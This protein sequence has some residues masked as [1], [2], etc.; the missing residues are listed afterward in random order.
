M[1][2]E[3]LNTHK[4]HQGRTFS[5]RQDQVRLPDGSTTCLDIV[6]H[7]G[8]VTIVPVDDQGQMWFVRQHRYAAGR[9]L[10]ELPAGSLEV[11]ELPEECA[12][13][14]IREEIG[15]SAGT[16][17]EIGTFF[18]APGYSTEFMHVFLAGDL[19]TD[20]LPGDADEFL[21]VECLPLSQAYELA[22][23]GQFADGKT[24]AALLLA[25]PYL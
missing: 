14:E 1:T 6:D 2:F 16:L 7:H 22:E 11:G 5:L 4:I 15:M 9:E 25:R 23:S 20:P 21:S 24:L 8:A 12:R 19:H 3:T 17:R 10:L 18:L 13:R